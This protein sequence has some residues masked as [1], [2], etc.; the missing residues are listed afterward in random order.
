VTPSQ[1]QPLSTVE[2]IRRLA[3]TRPVTADVA[4]VGRAVS[5]LAEHLAG[6]GVFVRR[7]TLAD[8]RPVL[9]AATVP[10]AAP[11]PILLNAH[12]DVVPAE[13]ATYE[14]REE[15]GWLRG[16]GTHDCLGNAALAANLL[17]AL[18]GRVR[19]GVLFS[20]DEETG[21]ASTRAMVERGIRGTE[22]IIVLDG[23]GYAIAVAQKGILT[24]RLVAHG[25]ACHAA[26]PWKGDNA[27]DRL[28]DGYTRLRGLFTKARK[29]D[30]WH[31]TL[32][33]TIIQAGS[34]RNRVPERAEMVVN[35]RFTREGDDARIVRLL[36]A[37]SGLSAEPAVDCQ[38]LVCDPAVPAL[39][40][41]ARFMEERL[42]RTIE[43]QRMNGATDA[44][45]FAPLGVPVAMIGVPGEGA[46]AA[47]ERLDLAALAAYERMLAA[48]VV[49]RAGL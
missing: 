34:V 40:D 46:H 7:E 8:G 10:E 29:G 24:V 27:I 2:L 42:G 1:Q 43:I 36:E 17:V 33:A 9:Y 16:R 39:R 25:A 20:T 47:G 18:N 11:P 13:E 21:G 37:E 12:L 5:L 19:C 28:V 35:I 15:N 6:Q 30:E 44:R 32:A 49:S 38:P 26:E 48:F 31:D 14:I 45:H 23:P 3:A 4:S 41:L 22:L